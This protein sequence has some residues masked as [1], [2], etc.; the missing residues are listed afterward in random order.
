MGRGEWGF[1]GQYRGCL[2][3]E[4]RGMGPGEWLI[5][6]GWMRQSRGGGTSWF[7][8]WGKAEKKE[9]GY[10]FWPGGRA[11]GSPG[12]VNEWV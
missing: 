4:G 10:G 1:P 2:S 6:A 3:R 11:V 7:E 5:S 9:W 8:V 12:Q